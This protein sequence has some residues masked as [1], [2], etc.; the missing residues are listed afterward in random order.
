MMINTQGMKRIPLKGLGN[1]RD[2]G[3]FPAEGEHFTRYGQFYRSASLA[4]IGE[5]G[6]DKLLEMGIRT[7]IDLRFDIETESEPSP[8]KGDDRFTYINHSLMKRISLDQI[9]IKGGEANTKS[10]YNMYCQVM[11][12]CTEEIVELLQLLT[13]GNERGGVLFHCAV[14]K[15]RTGITAMFLLALCGVEDRDIIADYQISGALLK[16]HTA[17]VSGSDYTNMERLLAYLNEKHG[18]PTAYLRSIGVPQT[19]IEK[20]RMALLD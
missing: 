20:L 1:F 3:G 9:D 6:R 15:D 2:L 18:S 19:N 4:H 7:V 10:L 17:D 11:E 13:D 5:E 14:G 8:I 16:G 12:N